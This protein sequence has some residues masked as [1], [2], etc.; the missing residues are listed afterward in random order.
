M[1]LP[2]EVAVCLLQD[3]RLKGLPE[4]L[5]RGLMLAR[6]G[7]HAAS[8]AARR[9]GVTAAPHA[10]FSAHPARYTELPDSEHHHRRGTSIFAATDTPFSMQLRENAEGDASKFSHARE[11]QFS[12]LC[13]CLQGGHGGTETPLLPPLCLALTPP[14]YTLPPQGFSCAHQ[15]LSWLKGRKETQPASMSVLVHRASTQVTH[16]ASPHLQHQP[17]PCHAASS[18]S[19]RRHDAKGAEHRWAQRL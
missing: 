19:A 8:D 9:R 6:L 13:T 2:L 17:R 15:A 5:C 1:T 3:W 18:F 12:G 10:S 11:V 16:K 14:C 4:S 7:T